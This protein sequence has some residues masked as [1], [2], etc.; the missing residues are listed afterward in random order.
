VRLRSRNDLSLDGT[1]PELADALGSRARGDL[2]VDGEVVALDR[3]GN[4]SFALLQRRLGLRSARESRASGVAVHYY[5]FD[6]LWADGHDLRALELRSRKALLRRAVALGGPLRYSA[7][8]RGSG[9][10]YYAHACR[11]GWEGVIAKRAASPYVGRRSPDWLKMKCELEQE[12][13]VGGFTDP[14]R[15]RVG[16]GAL[17]LGYHEDGGLRY[18]GKVGTGFDTASL[19]ELRGLLDGMTQPDPPFA[20]RVRERGARWVRPELVAQVRATEWTVDGRLRHPRFLGLR[21]DKDAADVVR[22]RPS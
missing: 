9:E 14:Q 16:F 10:A 17:L 18:A 3:A 11:R 2:V 13:V 19:L 12:L 15:S 1:Y 20:D 8:R 22:E 5:L 7:H 21:R 6:L 4:T